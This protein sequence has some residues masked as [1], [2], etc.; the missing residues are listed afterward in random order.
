M[1][2]KTNYQVSLTPFPT[3][4]AT[5]NGY[6]LHLLYTTPASVTVLGVQFFAG[7]VT[8]ASQRLGFYMPSITEHVQVD[9]R[10]NG[11]IVDPTNLILLPQS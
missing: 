1:T 8:G 10:H 9:I 4:I 2:L 7:K 3:E 11:N 5:G 6:I